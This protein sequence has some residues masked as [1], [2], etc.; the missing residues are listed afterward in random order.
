[1]DTVEET[2]IDEEKR[3]KQERLDGELAV[4]GV[5]KR[6]EQVFK[7][8]NLEAKLAA[9]KIKVAELAKDFNELQDIMRDAKEK[10]NAPRGMMIFNMLF[11]QIAGELKDAN[12]VI[13]KPLDAISGILNHYPQ[14]Y[15]EQ[16]MD[17]ARTRKELNRMQEA[18]H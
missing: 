15:K 16:N 17:I 8:S 5:L 18:S 9:T 1:M 11:A 13:E 3:E 4:L 14:Y 2:E 10:G 7:E 12:A 6:T